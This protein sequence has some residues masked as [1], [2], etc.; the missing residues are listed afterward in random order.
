M[1]VEENFELREWGIVGFVVAVL[2]GLPYSLE[3]W[4]REALVRAKPLNE[5]LAF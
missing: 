5:R 1:P 4:R 3:D 2:T